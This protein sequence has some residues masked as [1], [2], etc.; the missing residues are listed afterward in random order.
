MDFFDFH[1][2]NKIL[3][4]WSQWIRIVTSYES[5]INLILN[6]IVWLMEHHYNYLSFEVMVYKKITIYDR[7][8]MINPISTI[9]I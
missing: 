3:P 7:H 1:T 2:K 4:L 5:D 6:I 8:E 9:I